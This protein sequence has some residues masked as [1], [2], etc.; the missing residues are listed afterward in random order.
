[1]A[2]VPSRVACSVYWGTSCFGGT[3]NGWDVLEGG[4][5]Q[6]IMGTGHTVPS[7]IES[8][9]PAALENQII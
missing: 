8:I 6:K 9:L 2:V 4:P 7:K 1:M 5:P 3:P